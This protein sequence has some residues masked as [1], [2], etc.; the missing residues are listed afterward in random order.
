MKTRK[1]GQ[2]L[3]FRDLSVCLEEVVLES[4]LYLFPFKSFTIIV[5]L[6]TVEIMRKCL[7][8]ELYVTTGMVSAGNTERYAL[9]QQTVNQEGRCHRPLQVG[10]IH[11]GLSAVAPQ[12]VS[13]GCMSARQPLQ[14]T[15]T[16]PT[17]DRHGQP[18][19]NSREG[20][21]SI[22]K[23]ETKVARREEPEVLTDIS[24]DECSDP[25]PFLKPFLW[26]GFTV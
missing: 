4:L 2:F 15:K 20:L 10:P 13:V 17:A 9:R 23:L 8:S 18:A 6:P 24:K 19:G 12:D 26:S 11:G 1:T 22:C 25:H 3:G 21:Y 7:V 14:T 16:V 5:L